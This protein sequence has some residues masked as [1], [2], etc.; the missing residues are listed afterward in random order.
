MNENETANENEY[1]N[2]NETYEKVLVLFE[3]T[4]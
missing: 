2:G 4:V 3:D 1:A